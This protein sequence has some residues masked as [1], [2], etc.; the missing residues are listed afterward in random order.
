MKLWPPSTSQPSNHN[1]TKREPLLIDQYLKDQGLTDETVKIVE[2][3][4]NPI[5]E[6][7]DRHSLYEDTLKTVEG[8]KGAELKHRLNARMVVLYALIAPMVVIPFWLMWLLSP[9]NI[10]KYEEEMQGA[11]LGALASNVLGLCW[12]ITRDL[13]PQGSQDF[14]QDSEETENGG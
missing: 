12:I 2:P 10:D 3:V 9:G 8:R 7:I 11:L 14:M 13:F 1:P 4:E 5:N 6:F